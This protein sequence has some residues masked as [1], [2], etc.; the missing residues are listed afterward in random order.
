VAEDDGRFGPFQRGLVP[1]SLLRVGDLAGEQRRWRRIRRTARDWT[2]D[3]ASFVLSV[4]VGGLFLLSQIEGAV[5]PTERALV[6][7]DVLPGVV[8]CLGLW[9]RRRWPLGV[10][11]V[12]ILISAVSASSVVAA[13][14]A[15]FAV[16][17]HRRVGVVLPVAVLN[18]AAG[19]AYFWLRPQQQQPY[20]VSLVITAAVTAALVAWGMF[21]R[22]RRQLVW[23]LH[24]RAVRAEAEQRLLADQAR[25]AERA[26]IAREMHDVVAHRV[27]LMVLHAGALEVRPDLPPAEVQRIAGLIRATARQALEELRGVIGV[28]RDEA[29]PDTAPQTPQPTLTDISRLVEDSRRAGTNV[30]LKM[31]V[32]R[33]ESAPGALGRDAYRIV[34]EA[35]TNVN[36]HAT[37]TATTVTLAGGPGIGLRVAI[38]NRL[39]LDPPPHSPLPGA[40]M[41]L[42][43]LAERVSLSGGTLT[44]GPTPDGEFA[45]TAQLRWAE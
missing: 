6:V 31:H 27:S 23:S 26:R 24:D 15:L 14:I 41:G 33:P 35:L 3:A 43:G 2:V 38:R 28:L 7:V 34:Q 8:A 39:L 32:D 25:S 18:I 30:E 29:A 12:L 4:S 42:V 44:H 1:A 11:V 37:G 22:A 21:V 5:M 40:G 9:W 36:K 17:V 45:V 13:S 16:A 19:A 10:A 20:W